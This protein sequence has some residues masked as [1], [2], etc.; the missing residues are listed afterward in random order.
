MIE[1]WRK[2]VTRD[3]E[4]PWRMIG[5]TDTLKEAIE[6]SRGNAVFVCN[7]ENVLSFHPDQW[8]HIEK[9]RNVNYYFYVKHARILEVPDDLLDYR[10]K[11]N[12]CRKNA[13]GYDHG[14]KDRRRLS[15]QEK[16]FFANEYHY[17]PKEPP[18]FNW[19]ER[20]TKYKRVSRSWKDQSKR[21]HQWKLKKCTNNR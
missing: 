21:P 3:G 7:M 16:K 10:T 9:Y 13:V 6:Y 2:T 12:Y 17:Y 5:Y 14:E 18:T 19:T 8:Q 15:P 11:K 4:T 1:V 20:F